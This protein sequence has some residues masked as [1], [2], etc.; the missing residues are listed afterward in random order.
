MQNKVRV[1]LVD[2]HAVVRAGFSLLLS[3]AGIDVVGEAH[4]GEQACRLFE[5]EQ[6]DVVVMD[7]S[8]PGI[9]GL[10][11]IRR[12]CARNP[13]AKIL[14]FSIHDEPV[15]AERALQAGAK[16][17]I[18]KSSAPEILTE[19]VRKIALG[20]AY[21]EAPLL[22]KLRAK[23]GE[24][25]DGRTSR[26]SAREFD[27]FRLLAKGMTTHEIAGELCLAYKTVANYITVIKT[28]LNVS[29]AA[30]IVQLA[31]NDGILKP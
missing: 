12:I 4:K 27:V 2:D 30:E 28:K 31:I 29:T 6:P 8:M 21:V 13:Q 3:S 25:G 1:L 10:E 23:D 19:A 24:L 20:C 14:V 22:R 9:G 5:E 16:G 7:L 18:T 26:L 17:Y 11:T 15:Y